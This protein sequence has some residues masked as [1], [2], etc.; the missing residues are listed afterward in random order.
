MDY[1]FLFGKAHTKRKHKLSKKMLNSMSLKKL[2]VLA[3]KYKVSC[4]KKG[5][6]VCVKKSTLLK[7]LKKSRSINKILV[8]AKKMKKGKL[9]RSPRRTRKSPRRTRRSPKRK[10]RRNRFGLPVGPNQ[11]ALGYPLEKSV[12]QT[13]DYQKRH[14]LHTPTSLISYNF[15]KNFAY[16]QGSLGHSSLPLYYDYMS[17]SMSSHGTKKPQHKFG[18]YFQ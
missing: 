4:F 11:P 15:P 18:R 8:A 14:Y 13:Y 9:R 12:G 16:K 3:K 17:P 7:R 1:D 5:T 6:R 10:V 2:K